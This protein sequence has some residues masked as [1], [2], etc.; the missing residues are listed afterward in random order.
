MNW[1]KFAFRG[2]R[3]ASR[4]AKAG[5]ALRALLL[6]TVAATPLGVGAGR[7]ETIGGALVK[8][9]LTNPIINAQRATV[10]QTDEGVPEANAGYLPKVSATA[11]VAVAHFN[12]N[13]IIPGEPQFK[14]GTGAFPRGGG[15]E[16][17]ETLFDGYQTINK[18]RSAESQVLG[19]R[20]TLRNTEQNT[21]LTGVTAYMD[22]LRDTALLELQRNNVLVLQEQLR[23]TRD[24]FT[25]GEVTRTDVAQAEA[26]LSSSQ[27]TELSAES[28][29]EASIARYRQT[30]GDEP[31]TLA[32]AKPLVKPL[33]KTLPEAI[34]ISQVEH[35]AITAQLH[36]VDAAE[37]SVKIAEG[38]LAPS[39]SVTASVQKNYDVSYTPGMYAE[40]GQIQ[41]QITIPIYQGGAEYAS[42]RQ[43]KEALSVQELTA[44]S[45]R[46]QIRQNVVT[47]WGLN[48]AAV[49]VVR[50]ARAAVAANEVALA[51]V[52]EEA[53]VGQRTTLDVLNAQ[54][55]LLSARSQL[56]SA[57]HDAV[58]DSYSLLSAVGRLNVP[59]LGL[60][61]SEYDPRVHF[62]QVKDKWFGVRTPDGK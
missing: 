50:A 55:A 16:A 34:A 12:G 32:P 45:T 62:N 37:L 54:Q 15:V 58:V 28:T 27:A 36:G 24:R 53:K 8:A 4:S 59:T 18:I 60:A 41:G 48:Q 20:E 57:E 23:E 11:N 1:G 9:Y 5:G 13:E 19:A 33:P 40:V 44:D 61:V 17:Q 35:P 7:A 42:I 51:G 39:V 22:V 10:R 47:A 46:D 43:S 31:K 49:G 25:V 6:A 38:A 21:L 14:F 29:L 56:V 30:I 2:R 52:R 3:T 26:S